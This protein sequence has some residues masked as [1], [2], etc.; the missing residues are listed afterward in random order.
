MSYQIKLISHFH[1]II[2][3]INQSKSQ[4]QIINF[5]ILLTNLLWINWIILNITMMILTHLHLLIKES[6]GLAVIMSKCHS[7]RI[8]LFKRRGIKY[9]YSR[10]III[11]YY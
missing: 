5:L 4:Q 2:A 3:N 10:K 7:L 11:L 6:K 8:N 9:F 1:L